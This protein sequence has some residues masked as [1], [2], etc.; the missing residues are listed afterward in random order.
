ML[1]LKMSEFITVLDFQKGL[2]YDTHNISLWNGSKV[3]IHF[4]C[5]SGLQGDQRISLTF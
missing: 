2:Q 4:L 5:Y 3:V 1:Q